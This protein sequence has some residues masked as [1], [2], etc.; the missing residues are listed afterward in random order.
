M[1][2]DQK[3]EQLI[4]SPLVSIDQTVDVIEAAEEE[5][6]LE[7]AEMEDKTARARERHAGLIQAAAS[8]RAVRDLV[9]A[10]EAPGGQPAQDVPGPHSRACGITAHPHGPACAGDCPTCGVL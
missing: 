6:R 3:L 8:W 10:H 2:K 5:A 1:T 9:A 7:L 4:Q